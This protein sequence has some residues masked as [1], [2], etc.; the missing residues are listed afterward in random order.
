MPAAGATKSFDLDN[1]TSNTYELT[2]DGGTIVLLADMIF[3][4]SGTPRKGMTFIFNYGGG[5]TATAP[6]VV[7]IFGAT[8]TASQA[9]YEAVITCY[10]TGSAWRVHICTDEQTG[11]KNIDGARLIDASVT[12]TALAGSIAIT[13]MAV[14]TSRGCIPYGTVNGVWSSLDAKTAGY[15]LIGDG[16]D[17]KSV[18]SSGDVTVSSAGV[19]SIGA[20]KVTAAML[21]YAPQEY[22]E[23]SLTI[24][25]ASVLTLNATP[26]TIVAAPGVG[27]YIEVVSATSAM[28][29]V[30]AAYATNTTV[31]L[32]SAG[33]DVA[34][35][36]DTAILLSTVTKNTKFKD[37]TSA[38]A[39]QTQII[40][41][42]ALQVK[43]ATGNPITG[44][45][46]LEVKIIYRI[47]T[48]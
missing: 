11:N 5:V 30:S 12:S 34:Q 16:T 45:S 43:V 10:Y 39:G 1:T 7:S 40:D 15:L 21:A 36:Q 41:N 28:T 35:L 18:A 3:N 37:V 33:A 26:I 44:D 38:T 42:A 13:K 25:S 14:L 2:A 32:I 27:K 46:I 17:L 31:Q 29:F 4:T 22:F 23:A 8:L 24:V 9:L 48:I 20:G 47:V 19:F 6:I